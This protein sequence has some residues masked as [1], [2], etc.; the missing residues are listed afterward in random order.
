MFLEIH[1][2][3]QECGFLLKKFQ[4]KKTNQIAAL[5]QQMQLT[6]S[7]QINFPDSSDCT[8]AKGFCGNM[9][10][11]LLEES[12]DYYTSIKEML[13]QVESDEVSSLIPNTLKKAY[14]RVKVFENAYKH[15][16]FYATFLDSPVSY[17]PYG[18]LETTT[19]QNSGIVCYKCNQFGYIN[20]QYPNPVMQEPTNSTTS[21]YPTPINNRIYEE[22]E[23]LFLPADRYIKQKPIATPGLGAANRHKQAEFNPIITSQEVEQTNSQTL[24]KSLEAVKKN[25]SKKAKT[26]KASVSRRKNAKEELL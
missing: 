3:E 19:G 16:P 22:D 1:N 25:N 4:R 12:V 24:R 9:R 17:P 18:I 10:K 2:L 20:H 14:T 15:N 11:Q 13:R 7:L 21:I 8:N 26:K 6:S 23:S 5:V